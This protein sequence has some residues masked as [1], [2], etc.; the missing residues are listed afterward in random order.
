MSTCIFSV[1]FSQSLS[2]HFT[3]KTSLLLLYCCRGFVSYPKTLKYDSN[4]SIPCQL[5]SLQ[6]YLMWSHG[7][8]KLTWPSSRKL[9]GVSRWKDCSGVLVCYLS[10]QR[11]IVNLTPVL[12]FSYVSYVN[13]FC[14]LQPSLSQLDMASRSCKSW[15]PL[16]MTSSLSTHS[17]RTISAQSQWAS[18]SRAATS[19]PSTRS[20]SHPHLPR[21][22]HS[23]SSISRMLL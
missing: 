11:N 1:L 14:P 5:G 13:M 6:F 2:C 23:C 18:T 10:L 9:L 21:R 12:P 22:P 4:L 15:W 16:S 7:T 3:I 8:M 17:L 19:L 20:V